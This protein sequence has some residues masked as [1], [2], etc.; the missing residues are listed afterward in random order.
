MKTEAVLHAGQDGEE[1]A[2]E[3]HS[4]ETVRGPEAGSRRSGDFKI[5]QDVLKVTK[6]IPE[7]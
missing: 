3:V 6:S 1:S 5:K 4:R 2:T 7:A